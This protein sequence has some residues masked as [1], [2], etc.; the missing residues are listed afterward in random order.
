MI[1]SISGI[2]SARACPPDAGQK[3]SEAETTSTLGNLQVRLP[4][5]KMQ[6]DGGFGSVLL[7]EIIQGS[8]K[9]VIVN[10]QFRGAHL[11]PGIFHE[12]FSMMMGPA[13]PLALST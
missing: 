5:G 11:R 8:D 6:L 2:V 4:R 3:Q 7:R 9:F 1:L 10:P 12:E 13:P